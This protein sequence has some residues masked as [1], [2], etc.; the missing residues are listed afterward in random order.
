[1]HKV[2]KTITITAIS[3]SS[4]DWVFGSSWIALQANSTP[5]ANASEAKALS[6]TL[7]A[8]F[9]SDQSAACGPTK[10]A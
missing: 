2:T 10:Y 5:V 1:M 3:C 6:I 9:T 7:Q 4:T 8:V